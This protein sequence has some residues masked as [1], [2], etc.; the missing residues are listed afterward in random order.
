VIGLGP[1]T[2]FVKE[3]RRYLRVPGQTLLSP[4]ITTA[5]YLLV[6]GVALGGRVRQ[7]GGVPYLEFIVPGLI[8]LGVVSNAFLNTSSSMIGMKFGGTIVDLLVT[9][10][11]AG[12]IVAAMVGAAVTRAL[13]V[14]LLTWLVAIAANGGAHVAHAGYAVTFPILAAVGMAAM[15]LLT[16]I[17]ADNFER[18]NAIPTFVITP[19]TFLGGVFYDIHMLPGALATVSRFNPILYLVEGMR[20]GLIG[21]SAVDPNIGLAFLVG[22]D[23][24]AIGACVVAVRTGWHLRT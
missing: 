14:G 1:R 17:W 9:P 4:V 5:L 7:V 8:M 2:L 16:G 13:A 18:I 24:L 10:L 11:T 12:E 3:V 6:F 21:T 23:A 22:L 19:L 20:Y 15:G